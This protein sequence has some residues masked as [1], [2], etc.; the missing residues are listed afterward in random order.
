MPRYMALIYSDE[1]AWSELGEDERNA[2]YARY[3]EF[4]SRPEVVEGAELQPVSSA[5][6][7]RVRNDETLVTD[8]PYAEVKEA[9]GG[10]YVLE[11]DSIEQ[12][13]ELA[14]QIPAAEHGA[15]EIRPA[16]V[17]ASA[18]QQPE[19]EEVSA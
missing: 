8:G 2:I 19:R 4:S 7:V 16:Y 17:D 18:E 3:F 9:L 15:I 5:T 6:S 10:Y 14:A 11:C 13:C 12:A 1:Q